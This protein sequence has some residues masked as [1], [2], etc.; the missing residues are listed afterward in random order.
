[1]AE[2]PKWL[3]RY[4]INRNNYQAMTAVRRRAQA[5]SGARE[6]LLIEALF[7]AARSIKY[8]LRPELER[9]GLTYPMFI[10]LNQL[11]LDG[12]LSVG[13]LA[14]ACIVTP[15]NVSAAADDLERA[16]IVARSSS[17]TDRRVVLLTVTPRGHALHRALSRRLG[18]VLLGSMR[19]VPTSDLAATGRVL[20]RLA[21][22]A[23]SAGPSPLAELAP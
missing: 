11:V 21:S 1:V 3:S 7:A 12:P 16:G 8:R 20:A 4:I 2:D 17:P 6:E 19:G 5:A 22:T 15:A 10:A 14:G 9:Q 18:Q 13:A 23:G